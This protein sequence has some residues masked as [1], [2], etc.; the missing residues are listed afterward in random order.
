M[1]NSET[2]FPNS[3]TFL[4]CGSLSLCPPLFSLCPPVA[5]TAGQMFHLYLGLKSFKRSLS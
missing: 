3:I 4:G 5:I 2:F 1:P